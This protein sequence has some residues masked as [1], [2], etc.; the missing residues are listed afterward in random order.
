MEK[1]LSIG[2]LFD[3]YGS[4]LTPKQAR[5]VD[6]Y[7]NQDFSLSEI[8][9]QLDVTRQGAR[10]NITR[11][12]EHL[13]EWEQKL[14]AAKRFQQIS[15]CVNRMENL[16]QKLPEETAPSIREE[17]KKQLGQIKELL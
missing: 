11:G 15:E 14:H 7:Y 13:R 4:L 3:F 10:D 1:D 17:L 2:I 16:V 8:A 9:Q 5:A 12:A 6:Y